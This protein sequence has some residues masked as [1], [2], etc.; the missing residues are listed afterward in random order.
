MRLGMHKHDYDVWE[1]LAAMFTVAIVSAIGI[2]AF[3]SLVF[4]VPVF[5]MEKLVIIGW[6]FGLTGIIFSFILIRNW[7][8]GKH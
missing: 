2:L 4:Q 8:Q 3:I 5:D 6:I 1:T 7:N